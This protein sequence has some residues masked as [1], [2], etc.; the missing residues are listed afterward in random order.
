MS[1]NSYLDNC[2]SSLVL[3]T[4]EKDSI[5]TSISTLESRLNS[6]FG[7]SITEKFKFINL[8]LF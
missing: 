8:K 7:S 3:S 6:Y 5:T 1:V 4:N 2:A